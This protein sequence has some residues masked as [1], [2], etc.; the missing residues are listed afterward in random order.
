MF[1]L[2]SHYRNEGNFTFENLAAAKN[3]RLNWRNI[4]AL[5]HQTHDTLQPDNIIESSSKTVSLYAATQALLETL[6]DDLNTS[7]GMAI[8][9]GAFDAVLS[10]K[11]S[12]IH[13]HAF[14]GLLEMIDSL[15][16]LDIMK[17]SPD[18]SDD[19]KQL[20]VERAR[21]RESKDYSRS[22]E[23]RDELAKS[24]IAVRDTAF[25]SVWEYT[26]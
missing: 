25:G 15:Y 20:I 11:V 3:R 24:G 22:D 6:C 2:Q 9:D 12:D 7:E 8:I 23:I 4:A 21:V 16:G 19:L 13:Q 1:I 17:T 5:R 26:S 14:I 18:I 10:S